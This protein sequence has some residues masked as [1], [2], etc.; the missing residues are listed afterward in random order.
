VTVGLAMHW[1]C[2]TDL[3]G[4]PPTGSK[5]CERKVSTLSMP[6]FG[7]DMLYLYLTLQHSI[8]EQWLNS[9]RMPSECNQSRRYQ[10][11]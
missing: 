5:A 9:S 10:H 1:P 7:Y 2:M 4:Y 11:V 8:I 3:A 6:S